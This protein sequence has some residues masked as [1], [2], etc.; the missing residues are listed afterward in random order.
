M[1]RTVVAIFGS[2]ADAE[3]ARKLLID[4]GIP[5]E[6]VHVRGDAASSTHDD[7]TE[8]WKRLLGKTDAEPDRYDWYA[9]AERRGNAA[10]VIEDVEPREAA[11]IETALAEHGVLDIERLADDW[12]ARGWRRYEADAPALSPSELEEERRLAARTRATGGPEARHCVRVFT[13]IVE[14]DSAPDFVPGRQPPE[15]R[16]PK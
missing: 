3:A 9:E 14:D 10:L 13:I 16:A 1:N 11:T 5:P 6:D 8:A 12:R 15:Q 7:R 4:A 2:R